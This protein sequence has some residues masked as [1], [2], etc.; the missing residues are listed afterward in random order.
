[1]LASNI[2]DASSNNN[3]LLRS[4]SPVLGKVPDEVL[5]AVGVL[6]SVTVSTGV[7][8]AETAST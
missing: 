2:N 5:D 7:S 4:G 8:A 3:S 1:M 6:D